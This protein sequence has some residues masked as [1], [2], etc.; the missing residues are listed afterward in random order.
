MCRRKRGKQSEYV[1]KNQRKKRR[2]TNS[3]KSVSG[4]YGGGSQRRDFSHESDGRGGS[5]TEQTEMFA[6]TGGETA[7]PYRRYCRPRTGLLFRLIKGR[8]KEIYACICLLSCDGQVMGNGV[9]YL[10]E[11][12]VREWMLPFFLKIAENT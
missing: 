5:V 8:Q 7:L 6:L 4:K 9:S 11:N 3:D 1:E 12:T 10:L 2:D